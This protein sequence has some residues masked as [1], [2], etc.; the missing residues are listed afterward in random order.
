M[1]TYWFPMLQAIMNGDKEPKAAA[2]EFVQLSDQSI[3]NAQ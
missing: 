3:T 1:R 2:D